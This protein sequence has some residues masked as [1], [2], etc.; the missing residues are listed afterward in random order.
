[1][2]INYPVLEAFRGTHDLS[3]GIKKRKNK[4]ELTR[5]LND[6]GF[7]ILQ[8][9]YWPFLLSP[10]IFFV[11]T[12]QKVKLKLSKNVEINSDVNLP[13]YIFNKIFYY[14]TKA[15][16]I[17]PYKPWGSSLFIVARKK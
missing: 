2:I 12:I 9:D 7:S 15:E 5:L 3:V 11:R 16:I 8:N 4:N 1:M 14:L 13:P 6:S 10:I 17:L